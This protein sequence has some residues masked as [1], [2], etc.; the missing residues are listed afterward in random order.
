[1]Q[2]VELSDEA[3][4]ALSVLSSLPAEQKR[5]AFA[6]LGSSSTESSESST[7]YIQLSKVICDLTGTQMLPFSVFSKHETIATWK[8]SAPIISSYIE[9]EVK[10]RSHSERIKCEYIFCKI[11]VQWMLKIGIPVSIYTAVKQLPQLLG[12]V[13]A[14]FPG[15]RE[16][17]LLPMIL[18]AA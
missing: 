17:G 13:E 4:R 5:A 16:S 8:R 3:K 15:Y 7:L 6:M 9:R 10:P 2:L 11:L 1:M 14:E 12:C 18:R